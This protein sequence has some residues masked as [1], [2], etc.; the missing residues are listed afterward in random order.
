LLINS[1][2]QFKL[3]TLDEHTISL[4]A[5]EIFKKNQQTRNAY[6]AEFVFCTTKNTRYRSIE[7]SNK[8]RYLRISDKF[9]CYT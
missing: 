3:Y 6:F 2:T 5:G 1:L 9:V 4:H 8:T 7:I